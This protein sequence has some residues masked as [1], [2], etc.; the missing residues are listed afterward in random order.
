LET[1][2]PAQAGAHAELAFTRKINDLPANPVA[3]Y[4]PPPTFAY[5]IYI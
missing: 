3:F 5:A 4:P 1:V 2:T